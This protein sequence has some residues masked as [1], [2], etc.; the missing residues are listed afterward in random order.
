MAVC[1]R[2]RL[3][4]HRPAAAEGSLAFRLLTPDNL[5]A[6][7]EP[8]AAQGARPLLRGP[9]EA[10]AR[11]RYF[12]NPLGASTTVL[13]LRNER[14][15]GKLAAVHL[16]AR[17]AGETRRVGV[18]EGLFV[19]PAERSWPCLR[20]LLRHG[21]EE[22]VAAGVD[23]GISF[24]N[25]AGRELNHHCGWSVLG[26]L[27]VQSGFL[28]VGRA[29]VGRGL[30]APLGFVGRLA[31]PLVGVRDGAPLAGV[32]LRPVTTFDADFDSLLPDGIPPDGV[33][34]LKDAAY[35]QW[36]YLDCPGAA[37]RCL[38][39][40]RAGRPVGLVVSRT[41]PRRHDGYLL[42][43]CARD[44][45]P[46]LLEALAGAALADLRAEAVGLV[47]ASFP[48]RSAAAGT[49]QGLG[50]G[51]WATERWGMDL[52]VASDPA[53][54]PAPERDFRRWQLSLGD[55]LYF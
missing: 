37:Y 7:A 12:Q 18:N 35:L 10:V 5:P 51:S 3:P 27:P 19:L 48:E 4:L 30:P 14:L 33:A 25:P 49:L 13:A 2:G 9:A 31:Q 55:W 28:D 11:W 46:A 42:E 52:V 15:V 29:L 24:V 1:R 21:L 34:L 43:L 23:F 16:R 44:D 17:V 32:E 6:Y 38:A 40:Y 53:R 41:S 36:R 39:A 45:D 22:S 8:L 47:S 20:G 26:R 50:F 54:T